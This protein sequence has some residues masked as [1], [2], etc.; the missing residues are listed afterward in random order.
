MSSA[1]RYLDL[2][3]AEDASFE[4]TTGKNPEAW[5]KRGKRQAIDRVPKKIVKQIVV[6]NCKLIKT[7]DE[8]LLPA[9]AGK[10]YGMLTGKVDAED[11]IDWCMDECGLEEWQAY[12]IARD[13]IV[14]A[15]EWIKIADWKN[16][17]MNYVV[18]CH[19]GKDNEPR[20][21]HIKPWNGKSGLKSGKPNGLNGFVFAIDDPPVI[22]KKTGERGMPSTLIGCKCFLKAIRGA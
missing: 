12:R 9:L 4:W 14:K 6:E 10:I 13:Q 5:R 11:F 1:K 18:W 8:K 2:V 20:D 16:R 17:G 21:Y 7:V 22:D 19:S 15:R 3:S